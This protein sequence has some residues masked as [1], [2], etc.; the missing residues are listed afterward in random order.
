MN[1]KD[2]DGDWNA[3]CLKMRLFIPYGPN[4]VKY[5]HTHLYTHKWLYIHRKKLLRNFKNIYKLKCFTD[6]KENVFRRFS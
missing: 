4:C 6:F 3:G 1:W 2:R 5:I